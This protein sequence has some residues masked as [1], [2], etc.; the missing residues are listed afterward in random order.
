MLARGS[1]DEDCVDHAVL[2]RTRRDPSEADLRLNRRAASDDVPR[3][4][5]RIRR[6]RFHGDDL[7]FL[8]RG[9][10]A[11]EDVRVLRFQ[12]T[13]LPV[14][15]FRPVEF[16]AL[17]SDK[18]V[19]L[20]PTDLSLALLPQRS[21]PTAGRLPFRTSLPEGHDRTSRDASQRTRVY[22]TV[23]PL[24]EVEIAVREDV[25][26]EEPQQCASVQ[27]REAGLWLPLQDESHQEQEP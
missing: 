2:A 27:E 7:D 26:N 1:L 24:A 3:H 8:R 20:L 18:R 19:L 21:I 4:E 6:V 25:R 14:P 15:A 13:H 17:R 5:V 23:A 11:V 9:R 12:D 22:M 16:E 10:A